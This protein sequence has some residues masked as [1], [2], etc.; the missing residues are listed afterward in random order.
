MYPIQPI[1]LKPP[2]IKQ[3]IDKITNSAIVSKY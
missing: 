1:L 2:K 3:N